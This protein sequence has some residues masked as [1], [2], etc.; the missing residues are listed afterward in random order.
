[1][2]D[3]LMQRVAAH[4]GHTP[5]ADD[6]TALIL[7]SP[8]EVRLALPSR[9]GSELIAAEHAARFAQQ[10]GISAWA[11]DVATA[12]GEA[13]L[14]AI[15]HGNGLREAIPVEVCFLAGQG[16]VEVTVKDSGP[17]FTPPAGPPDLQAQMA[18]DGPI[19]GWGWHLIRSLAT[20][21]HIESLATGK[22]VRLRFGGDVGV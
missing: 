22:Q 19:R 7:I 18:G 13:C 9:Y 14:N 4:T 21:L 10:N 20:E 5:L 3:S 6:V 16:W 8:P 15:T 1:M 11:D 17:L 12:V 2:L